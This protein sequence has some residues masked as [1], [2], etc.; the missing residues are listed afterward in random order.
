MNLIFYL[1]SSDLQLNIYDML[2]W[3]QG[4]LGIVSTSNIN[5]MTQKKILDFFKN[6]PNLHMRTSDD[7]YVRKVG[8]QKIYY[9]DKSPIINQK[10]FEF[11]KM[12]HFSKFSEKLNFTKN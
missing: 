9:L 11:Y 7:I 6:L 8:F 10:K 3:L 12:L 4:G 1:D 5:C 2:N